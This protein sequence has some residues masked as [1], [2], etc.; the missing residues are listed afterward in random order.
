MSLQNYPARV[1]EA[2]E[3]GNLPAAAEALS[4]VCQLHAET[5]DW[6]GLRA[7]VHAALVDGAP[8]EIVAKVQSTLG[9]LGDFVEGLDSALSQ[10]FEQAQSDPQIKALYVEY[11]FDGGDASTV[12][13]FTC[14]DYSD[15]GSADWTGQHSDDGMISGPS[16][17]A[18]LD[19]DPDIEWGE[20]E[21]FLADGYAFAHLLAVFGEVFDRHNSI[22]LPAAF[23]QHDGI[24]IH[25]SPVTGT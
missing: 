20:F 12:D 11:F 1:R 4:E 22:G 19:Y 3:A 9:D 21:T 25:L 23:A 18:L 10:A 14:T 17:Q 16:V 15:S 2:A 7:C 5:R 8:E 6:E 24:M 13:I